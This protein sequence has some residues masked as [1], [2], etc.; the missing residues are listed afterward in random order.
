[1][2]R[3]Y[4]CGCALSKK[5]H[6]KEHLPPRILIK[7]LLQKPTQNITINSCQQCNCSKSV[8]DLKHMFGLLLTL[9][10]NKLD[11]SEMGV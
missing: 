1:M 2:R 4:K 9:P 6:S 11:I 7:C 8:A 5:N 3:C 10:Q